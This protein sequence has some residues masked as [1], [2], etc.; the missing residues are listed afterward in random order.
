LGTVLAQ[1]L[2]AK[3]RP[4]MILK[5]RLCGA[6]ALI[7]SLPLM[8]HEYGLPGAAWAN[9]LYF[10]IEALLLALLAKPWRRIQTNPSAMR[11]S[12]A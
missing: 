1:P 3:K 9:P 10:G 7:I 5:G 6:L 4:Q 2:L 11:F 12:A 8:L